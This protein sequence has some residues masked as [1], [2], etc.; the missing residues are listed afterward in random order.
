MLDS[1]GSDPNFKKGSGSEPL[2]RCS[3]FV[4]AP[5]PRIG[6]PESGR[7]GRPKKQKLLKRDSEYQKQIVTLTIFYDLLFLFT[8]LARHGIQK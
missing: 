2:L 6:L 3:E 8:I 1:D 7:G 4:F 5:H